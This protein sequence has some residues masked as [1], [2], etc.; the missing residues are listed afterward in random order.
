MFGYNIVYI[1]SLAMTFT[2]YVAQHESL[3]INGRN[4]MIQCML[5]SIKI[6][7]ST[8]IINQE[9]LIYSG[10]SN[11]EMYSTTISEVDS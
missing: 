10:Y 7:N 1:D 3:L 8:S 2:E 11:I 4:Y 9:Y 6:E 5:C